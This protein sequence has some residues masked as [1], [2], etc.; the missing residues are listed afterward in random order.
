MNF[1]VFQ[2]RAALA[3]WGEAAVGSQRGTA[4]QPTHSA[5]VGLVGA[6]LGVRREDEAAHVALRDGFGFAV[7]TLDNGWLLRDYHTVQMPPRAALKG[8]PHASR[9]DELALPRHELST[10]LSVR[11]HRQGGA[12]LV[13]LAAVGDV[14]PRWSLED[15]ADALRRPKFLLSLGRRA[16]PPET[17]LWPALLA[18]DDAVAA[19]S[20][21]LVRHAQAL[22]QMSNEDRVEPLPT[23]QRVSVD[24]SLRDIHDVCMTTLRKDRVIRREGWQFGD[25]AEHVVFVREG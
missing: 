17:P 4:N 7:A 2:L 5:I 20:D 21:Y 24:D 14:E 3:A 10:I 16:C 15:L 19:F 13:A 18:A 25:R 1:L 9:R 6:A 8:R 23:L 12:W 11:D 22:A